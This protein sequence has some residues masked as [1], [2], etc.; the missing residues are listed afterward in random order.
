MESLHTAP[1]ARVARGGAVPTDVRLDEE[2][3]APFELPGD[4]GVCLVIHGFTGTPWDVRPLGEALSRAGI[5]VHGPRLPGHG[6]TPA[7]MLDARAPDWLLACDDALARL[8]GRRVAVAGLS[9]GALLAL[10]LAARHPGRVAGV[11]ALA[12]A[13]RFRDRTLNSLRAVRA[14]VPLLEWLRPWVLKDATDL[15]DEGARAEAPVLRAWPSARLRDLWEIQDLAWG[16][17]ARVTCPVLVLVAAQDHVVDEAGAASLVRRL[18]KSPSV[19]YVR[20]EDSAHI[21]PRD[22]N[23]ELVAAEVTGF[24]ERTLGPAAVR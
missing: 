22:R 16:S 3:T 5:A 8:P 23:R 20:I 21:L 13:V 6:T 1:A 15:L 9:M 7:A 10:V 4:R 12:P 11:A 24:V 17:A 2:K 19:R 14:A 18:E